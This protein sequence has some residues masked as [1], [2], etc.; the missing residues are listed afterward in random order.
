MKLNRQ[1]IL[2]G[3]LAVIGIVR[4]G[5]WVLASI[6]EGPLHELR[7]TNSQLQSEIEKYE[8]A[9]ALARTAGKRIEQWKTLSLPADVETSRTLYR[10]WLAD[11]VRESK[12]QNPIVDSGGPSVR[13]GLYRTLPFNLRASGSLD[14][15][16]RFLFAFSEAGHLHRIQSLTLTP[17]SSSGRFDVSLSIETVLLPAVERNHLTHRTSTIL[18][19]HSPEDYID[20]SRQ[21]IFGAESGYIDPHEDTI[22]SAITYSN[23]RPKVWITQQSD[24]HVQKLGLDDNVAVG[25]FRGRIVKVTDEDVIIEAAS[26]AW[27]LSIGDS[28]ADA[29]FVPGT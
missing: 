15:F 22:V 13:Y 19:S 12:L 7:G 20:I 11:L 3:L 5:D 25:S 24:N 2:L 26:G 28:F 21:N 6:I 9:L 16:T 8:K 14:Q 23:G 17:V 4:V 29:A 1:K 27:R 18:A 10:T